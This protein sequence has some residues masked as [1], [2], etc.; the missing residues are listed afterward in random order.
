MT[1]PEHPAY[2]S[3]DLH[4]LDLF[5]G[6]GGLDVAAHFLGVPSLGIEMD[7]NACET[8]YRAGL[9]T[10]HADVRD[11]RTERFDEL[12]RT[13]NVLA[14]GPPCQ[15]F[16]VAGSGDG[17]RAL[18]T[19]EEFVHQL[20]DGVAD[21]VVDKELAKLGDKRTA[22]VLE[23]IRWLLKAIATPE[24]GPYRAIVLEQV[25]TVLP[26]W[27]L[28]AKILNSGDLPGGVK[29]TAT[30]ETLQTEEYGVPQTR[31]RAV[32]LARLDS[33]G[34]E[35][36]DWAGARPLA[37]PGPTHLPFVLRRAKRSS[38]G[39]AL[40]DAPEKAEG[41]GRRPHH[42]VSAQKALKE[43][44]GIALRPTPFVVVSNYSTG[45]V[46]TNRGRRGSHEPAFTVTSK[47]SRNIVLNEDGSPQEPD[48]F[49]IPEAGV[50]Q[51]FPGNFPW[52]GN[53]QA[54][55]VGNAVPPRFAMHVLS[56]TLGLGAPSTPALVK[57]RSWPPCP[58]PETERLRSAGC[59]D[60]SACPTSHPAVQASS[61]SVVRPRTGT[62]A[63]SSAK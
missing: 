39:P 30:C 7:G 35:R 29:Y 20:L 37:L 24:R 57:A 61:S 42:W 50:L 48:R 12:P 44:V 9:P 8:R 17:R 59:G 53:A 5:A 54:E 27:K 16:S 19:I 51:S 32:L 14:G 3:Q 28:Y 25:T 1:S 58:S 60:R 21:E 22:L 18:S 33:V 52:S 36:V 49:T 31:K 55:Q 46:S 56:A 45:G 6:P 41:T 10:I 11:M 63:K 43:A 40:F 2:K 62:S 4:I 47:I 34:G 13:I 38:E 15:S 23:P 26:L